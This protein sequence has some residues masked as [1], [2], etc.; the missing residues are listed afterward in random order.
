MLKTLLIPSSFLNSTYFSTCNFPSVIVFVLSNTKASHLNIFSIALESLINIPCLENTL[1]PTSK[2]I[3]VAKPK[4]QGQEIV[5]TEIA[6]PNASSKGD[7]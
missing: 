5:N 3:G 7:E 1:L 4:A 6:K 2:E